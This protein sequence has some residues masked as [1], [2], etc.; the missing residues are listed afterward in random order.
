[1]L[2]VRASTRA[3]EENPSWQRGWAR[4]FRNVFIEVTLSGGRGFLRILSGLMIAIVAVGGCV[5]VVTAGSATVVI[6]AG[7]IWDSNLSKGSILRT[8]FIVTN[9]V[10]VY[11]WQVNATW[12]PSV[13]SLLNFSIGDFWMKVPGFSAYYIDT[14]G[15][16][17]FGHTFLGDVNPRLPSGSTLLV[18]VAFRILRNN[19]ETPIHIG[20]QSTTSSYPAETKLLP[21]QDETGWN[22]TPAGLGWICLGTP[23]TT[24]DGYFTNVHSYMQTLQP[25]L[26][27]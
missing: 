15:T 11:G 26:I 10:F 19:S 13:L 23:Y 12:D 17:V 20:V 4:G 3:K 27:R 1:M 18:T 5:E 2:A 25:H 24:V 7:S 21:T 6:S 8:P 9:A 16:F 14:P 22:C